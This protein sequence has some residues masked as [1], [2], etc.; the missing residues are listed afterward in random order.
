[1]RQHAFL[2][3]T[4]RLATGLVFAA[5]IPTVQAGDPQIE[6]A[7]TIDNTR[8]PA[9]PSTNKGV[10]FKN[11]EVAMRSPGDQDLGEQWMLKYKEK[12]KPFSLSA[13]IAGFATDN[14]AL[15]EL[16][17]QRDQFMV[18]QVAA[19]YQP[20]ITENLLAEF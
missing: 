15:T 16:G 13:D 4:L 20:K 18:G 11:E 10:G 7:R 1:M 6:Q 8:N 9:G 17:T 19:S 2:Q 5:S 14:V 3:I 12:E